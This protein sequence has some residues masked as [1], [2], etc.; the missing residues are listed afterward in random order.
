MS[1]NYEKFINVVY[2]IVR[3]EERIQKVKKRKEHIKIF[4][5]YCGERYLTVAS[6]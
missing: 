3:K 4:S 5:G 6:T 2:P 1:G